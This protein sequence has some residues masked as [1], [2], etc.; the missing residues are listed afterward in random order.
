MNEREKTKEEVLK[1]IGVNKKTE[2]II[3][4]S[5]VIEA[6]YQKAFERFKLGQR[7]FNRVR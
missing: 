1:K 7:T 3:K 5:R 2:Q 4:D 6:T